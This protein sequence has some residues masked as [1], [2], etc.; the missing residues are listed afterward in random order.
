MLPARIAPRSQP[1]SVPVFT[2]ATERRLG[3][4]CCP[5]AG[6]CSAGRWGPWS[7][8]RWA[9]GAA[10]RE[11][12]GLCR[13]DT[14]SHRTEPE[15]PRRARCVRCLFHGPGRGRRYH[16]NALLPSPALARSVRRRRV[17]A[18]R[19]AQPCPGVPRAA[20]A[21]SFSRR[22]AL[23]RG[24][25]RLGSVVVPRKA[26]CVGQD[27]DAVPELAPAPLSVLPACSDQ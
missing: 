23:L 19:V 22:G 13:G 12:A 6:T 26:F 24:S 5:S 27:G 17:P 25:G 15:P 9:A 2:R 3:V 21:G 20:G 18:P 10:L 4:G 16:G 11:A 7:S 1:C 8:A 14:V